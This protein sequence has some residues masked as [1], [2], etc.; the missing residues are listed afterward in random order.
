MDR[1]EDGVVTRREFPG[2][3]E[4]FQ[5]LDRDGDGEI[6]AAEAIAMQSDADE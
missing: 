3:P 1:N 4:K 5:Q 2:P 6:D